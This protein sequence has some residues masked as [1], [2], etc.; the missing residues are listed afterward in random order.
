MEDARVL[1]G[2]D[3]QGDL[4]ALNEALDRSTLLV[5]LHGATHGVGGLEGR[6]L[7]AVIVLHR[8]LHVLLTLPHPGTPMLS[9]FIFLPLPHETTLL[10][11]SPRHRASEGDPSQCA[12][13]PREWLPAAGPGRARSPA[14]PSS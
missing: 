13:R 5:A 14:A 3:E 11:F 2:R 8:H 1:R 4:A 6:E 9:L 10:L 12:R 7:V